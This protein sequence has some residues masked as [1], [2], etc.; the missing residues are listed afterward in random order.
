MMLASVGFF[1]AALLLFNKFNAAKVT[2]L[3]PFLAV[4][5]AAAIVVCYLFSCFE[6]ITVTGITWEGMHGVK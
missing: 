6:L 5:A 2:N 1:V 4:A 3:A